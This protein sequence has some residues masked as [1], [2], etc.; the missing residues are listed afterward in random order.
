MGIAVDRLKSI[1]DQTDSQN[2]IYKYVKKK[3]ERWSS[4]VLTD[5]HPVSDM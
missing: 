4:A 3:I 5:D 2:K 1:R